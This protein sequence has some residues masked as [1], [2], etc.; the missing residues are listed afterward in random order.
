MTTTAITTNGADVD[1]HLADLALRATY[2]DGA[3]SELRQV[4]LPAC[5]RITGRRGDR[6]LAAVLEAA[7]EEVSDW[8]KALA[9]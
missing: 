4:L 2:E 3:A 6:F 7:C 8:A 5:R 9:R 1:R